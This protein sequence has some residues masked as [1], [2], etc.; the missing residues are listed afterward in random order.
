M[1]VPGCGAIL[2]HLQKFQMGLYMRNGRRLYVNRG[3]GTPFL[4]AA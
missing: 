2:P 1:R 4:T 3:V